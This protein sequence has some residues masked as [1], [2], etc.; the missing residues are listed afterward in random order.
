MVARK[1]LGRGLEALIPPV[2]AEAEKRIA[3]IAVDKIALNPYRIR[4]EV[5]QQ[6]L[7]E[8]ASSIKESG[9]IQP[10]VVRRSGARYELICGE[11]RLLAAREAGMKSIPA[12][13]REA[14]EMEALELALVENLQRE[15]LNPMEEAKAYRQL[16][17]EFGLTQE[18]IALRA[19]RDRS[20]IANSLRLLNLPKKIQEHI[21]RGELTP[22]HAR[23]LLSLASKSLQLKTGEEIRRRHLSVREAE[24]LVLT[25]REGKRRRHRDARIV[26]LEAELSRVLGTR[27]RIVGRKKGGKLEIEFYSD[28]DLQRILEVM[29]IGFS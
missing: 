12:I 14:S 15:N 28:S 3:E 23:A 9:V 17:K 1:A 25:R 7:S 6:G 22:G 20:T 21:A 10:V 24:R 29:G 16:L 19:G 2:E 26:A 11:R 4:E 8:L 18:E 13:V 5:G 27:V